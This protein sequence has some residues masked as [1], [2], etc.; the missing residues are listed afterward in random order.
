[1]LMHSVGMARKTSRTTSKK[2]G[3]EHYLVPSFIGGVIAWYF[4]ESM[5]LGVF[6]FLAVLLGNYIGFKMLQK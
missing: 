2:L 3:Y 6:V 1:M 4:A 5:M